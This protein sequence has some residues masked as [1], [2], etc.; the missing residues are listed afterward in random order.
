MLLSL[1]VNGSSK[2]SLLVSNLEMYFKL[3]LLRFIFTKNFSV[4]CYQIIK[5][6]K[7]W[8]IFKC[9]NMALFMMQYT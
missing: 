4:V 8:R 6:P 7:C 2:D 5:V 3:I 9:E 1:L